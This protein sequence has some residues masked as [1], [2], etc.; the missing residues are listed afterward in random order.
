VTTARTDGRWCVVAMRARMAVTGMWRRLRRRWRRRR[1]RRTTIAHEIVLAAMAIA[2][3]IGGPAGEGGR[4]MAGVGGGE[5]RTSME[6]AASRSP[7]PTGGST[8]GC[9]ASSM[10]ARGRRHGRARLA[11]GQP[12]ACWRRRR[13]G[14]RTVSRRWTAKLRMARACAGGSR[15]RPVACR[16]R[17]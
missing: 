9:Y 12:R 2:H 11:R 6:A 7:R 13:D 1:R 4:W 15:S 16:R 17:R 3:G 14:G 8:R 5:G 10:A